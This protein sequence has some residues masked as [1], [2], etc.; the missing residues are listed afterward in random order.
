MLR[1]SQVLIVFVIG[2]TAGIGWIDYQ[3]GYH[4]TMSSLYLLPVGLAAWYGKRYEGYVTAAASALVQQFSNDLAGEPYQSFVVSIWN[5][6]VQAVTFLTVAALLRHIRQSLANAERL[7]QHDFL[8]GLPNRRTFLER[9][10]AELARSARQGSALA[11]GFLDLDNFKHVNDS[12]GH[13]EGDRLLHSTATGLSLCLRRSD[14]LA[15]LSG[16]EFG[17]LLPNCDCAAAEVVGEKI[18][19]RMA[20]LSQRNNWPV[21]LSAGLLCVP[22][23]SGDEEPRELLERADALMYK[24]KAA[25]RNGYLVSTA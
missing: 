4:F 23:P 19:A 5:D 18:V 15:R 22:R 9:L 6:A 20:E 11:V 13:S 12:L 17:L 16:D 3:T 8:T 14:L 21:S 10:E 7:A 2:L 25:G 24:V 1:N